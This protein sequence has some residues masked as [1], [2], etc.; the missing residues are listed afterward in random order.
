MSRSQSDLVRIVLQALSEGP[1]TVA[2]INSYLG[3]QHGWEIG[4]ILEDL[5][6]RGVVSKQYGPS[7]EAFNMLSS[8]RDIPSVIYHLIRR[9]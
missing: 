6:E 7:A 1:K 4:K 3:W 8:L 2:D 9:D 5:F